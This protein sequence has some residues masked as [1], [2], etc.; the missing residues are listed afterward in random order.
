MEI[1]IFDTQCVHYTDIQWKVTELWPFEY[2]KIYTDF[3]MIF[4]KIA[5]TPS[6][7]IETYWNFEWIMSL[8]LLSIFIIWRLLH[9][10]SV[11]LKTLMYRYYELCK[12]TNWHLYF[13]GH[14]SVAFPW[15]LVHFKYSVQ[16]VM[17]F[18]FYSLICIEISIFQ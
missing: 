18:N 8:P 13:K 12:I 3:L 15:I 14:N 17:I 7:I 6:N 9:F 10:T 16:N 5:I 1:I 2:D 4:W 11:Y